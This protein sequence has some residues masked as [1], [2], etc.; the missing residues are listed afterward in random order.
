M[1]RS[2]KGGAAVVCRSCQTLDLVEMHHVRP[3]LL[4]CAL[5]VAVSPSQAACLRNEHGVFEE[6]AC[7]SEAL[8][9]ADQELNVTYKKL[10]LSLDPTQRKLLVQSQRSW[11]AFLNAQVAFLFAVEGD[12]SQGRLVVVNAKEQHTRARTNELQTWAPQ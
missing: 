7:A 3:V 9:S 12:G 5:L 1:S 11:L 6:I 4:A 8:A 10:R 2:V